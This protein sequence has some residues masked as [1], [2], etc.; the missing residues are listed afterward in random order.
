[1]FCRQVFIESLFLVSM[2]MRSQTTLEEQIANLLANGEGPS[3]IARK[4]GKDIITVLHHA[5]LPSNKIFVKTTMHRQKLT[6]EARDFVQACF[7]EG[8]SPQRIASELGVD[9]R[10]I[11]YHKPK[12]QSQ[13]P[14]PQK[15]TETSHLSSYPTPSPSSHDS[16]VQSL[17]QQI[18][19]ALPLSTNGNTLEQTAADPT[20]FPA[21]ATKTPYSPQNVASLPTRRASTYKPTKEKPMD[22]PELSHLVGDQITQES[23]R[24]Q[25][26]GRLEALYTGLV[27]SIRLWNQENYT[28]IFEI[29][30]ETVPPEQDI[31][32]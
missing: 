15:T 21:V 11:S 32:R 3:M 24:A 4:L 13:L 1:M 2:V 28:G 25:T 8:A 7:A 5:Y 22:L 20:S 9:V 31:K 26:L 18:P 27:H 19:Q 30:K 17:D 23:F 6:P 14:E 10:T 12:K 29:H 16:E